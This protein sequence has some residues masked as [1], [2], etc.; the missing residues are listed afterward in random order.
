[1]KNLRINL[2]KCLVVGAC[3]LGSVEA[4]DGSADRFVDGVVNEVIDSVRLQDK[5]ELALLNNPGYMG[6]TQAVTV[7]GVTNFTGLFRTPAKYQTN[8]FINYEI[9][10]RPSLSWQ[11]GFKSIQRTMDNADFSDYGTY[12]FAPSSGWGNSLN[13][14]PYGT[15]DIGYQEF[16]VGAKNYLQSTGSTA[17]FGGYLV[18]NLHY[19]LAS[20]SAN[21]LTWSDYYSGQTL[22]SVGTA[23][24]SGSLVS[25]SYGFGF[26]NVLFDQVGVV[27]EMTS[28]LTMLNSGGFSVYTLDN[29]TGNYHGVNQADVMRRVMLR[30][31]HKSQWLQFKL[32]VGY[33][34]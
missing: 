13:Y 31:F 10:R 32:G 14:K 17:P 9:A 21:N 28:G 16:T 20:S 11:F 23:G 30:E 34:F 18:V 4:V 33:L 5:A 22:P 26:R 19:G 6:L 12:V 7:M 27:F 24:V 15:M 3:F 29:Y 25:M 8:V 1:M 2:M